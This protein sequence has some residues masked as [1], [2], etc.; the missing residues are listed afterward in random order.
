MFPQSRHDFSR[1]TDHSDSGAAFA[2]QHPTTRHRIRLDRRPTIPDT[3]D[4]SDITNN[5]Q[6]PGHV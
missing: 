6:Q 1:H 4:T 3:T 2:K 5:R